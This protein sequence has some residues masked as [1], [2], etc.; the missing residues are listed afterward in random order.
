VKEAIAAYRLDVT[1]R[2]MEDGEL[3]INLIAQIDA[4]TNAK[5]PCLFVLDLNLPRMSGLDVLAC[6]RRSKKCS[7]S[8]VLIIS[9]S[10]AEKDRRESSALGASAYFTKPSGYA[11]FLELGAVIRRLVS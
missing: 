10:D 8:P 1:L 2:V 3:A 5:C 11:A 4:D 9:S 6:V 7:K